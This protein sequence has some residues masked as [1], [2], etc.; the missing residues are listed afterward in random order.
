MAED[1]PHLAG[2]GELGRGDE[3]LLAHGEEPAAH[4]AGE[5]GPA[6]QRD[7][8]GDREVD[9]GHAPGR[10]QS[11]GEPHPQRDG[12]DRAQDLDHALDDDVDPAAMQPGDAAQEDAQEQRQRHADKADGQRGAARQQQSRPDVPAQQVGAEEKQAVLG[13]AVGD[14]EQV[15]VGREQAQ[16]VV[17]VA[18]HE[19]A[20][21]AL[22]ARV[23]RVDQLEGAR[24]RV[25]P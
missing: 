9:L 18:R 25:R 14:A 21:I 19:Q 3:V 22:L 4:D 17:A 24:R 2:A 13:P 23:R 16:E 11:G 6:D 10:R 7:D 1:D 20:Q 8:D 15:P 12:G 5:L